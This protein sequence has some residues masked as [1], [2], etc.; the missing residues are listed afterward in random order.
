MKPE[1]VN[2]APVITLITVS[3]A[4]FAEDGSVSVPGELDVVLLGTT[5][6]VAGSYSDTGTLDTHAGS[7]NWGDGTGDEALGLFPDPHPNQSNGTTDTA[8]HAYYSDLA[9]GNYDIDLTITDDDTGADTAAVTM[10]T[11]R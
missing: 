8:S 6:E 5:I 9:P 4:S 1:S 10:T 2:V 7:I 11:V 3:P